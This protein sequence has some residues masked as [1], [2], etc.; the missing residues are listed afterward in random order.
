MAR[1]RIAIV[2]AGGFA[3]EVRWL[4]EEIDRERHSFECVG[5]LVSDLSNLGEHDSREDVLGDLTWLD[6]T[7]G[8][9][10]ALAIGIGNP[11]VRDRLGRELRARHPAL[12]LPPLVHPT[13]RMDA[14]CRLGEGVLVCAG[15]IFTVNVEIRS[16][17]MVNLSCTIGHEAILGAGCVLNPTVNVSGGV[18]LGDRV[19]V[20]TGAQ[21]LQYV[22]IGADAV[23]GAGAVVTKD[24]PEG[25]TVAGVPAR[26][27]RRS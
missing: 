10:D 3:R 16:Y 2:G 25:M 5:F 21:I 7:P 12:E 19:L 11:Q 22:D 13:A 6:A 27:L 26:E 15:N 4:V 9:V 20:G 24:V 18:A 1:C 14:S 8:R 23:I 17:A